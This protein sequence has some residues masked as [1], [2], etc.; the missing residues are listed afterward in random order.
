MWLQFGVSDAPFPTPPYAAE[1]GR[2]EGA[3][4]P[5]LAGVALAV[6][7]SSKPSS[8]DAVAP[9]WSPSQPASSNAATGAPHLSFV[10]ALR[11]S[12][13]HRVDPSFS[14]GPSLSASSS[15]SGDG[16]YSTATPSPSTEPAKLP[17]IYQ[18]LTVPGFE[19]SRPPDFR[20]IL[21]N[22][23]GGSSSSFSKQPPKL[24]P[25]RPRRSLRRSQSASPSRDQD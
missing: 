3:K 10:H 15:A 22:W 16:H 18:V 13:R 6:G 11:R 21:A 1:A 23:V 9:A 7:S 25:V 2:V 5:T 24:D 4:G 8:L 19:P 12:I 14:Q 20:K 17:V